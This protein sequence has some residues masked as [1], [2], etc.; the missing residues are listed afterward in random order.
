VPNF[1][2][3]NYHVGLLHEIG[4]NVNPLT[5]DVL[6][7]TRNCMGGSVRCSYPVRSDLAVRQSAQILPYFI[8]S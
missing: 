8:V 6:V 2:P 3:S 7:T 5:Q 4:V 1:V